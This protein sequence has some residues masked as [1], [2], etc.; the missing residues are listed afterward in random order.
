MTG[1]EPE[2]PGYQSGV[3]GKD[4][5]MEIDTG[6]AVSIITERISLKYFQHL[7]Q[8]ESSLQ[9]CTYT[10]EIV[11]PEGVLSVLVTY[12]K[13]VKTLP[14]YVLKSKGPCLFGRD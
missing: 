11:K 4:L 1:L 6:S 3:K 10:S 12:Q 2:S 7:Q 14:L 5:T 8:Q 9:L 13:Q